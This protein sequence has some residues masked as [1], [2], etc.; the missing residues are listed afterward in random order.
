MFGS[1]LRYGEAWCDFLA[2][3]EESYTKMHEV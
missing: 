1:D 3:A 2:V